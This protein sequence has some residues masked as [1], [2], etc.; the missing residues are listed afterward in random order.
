MSRSLLGPL[1][2]AALLLTGCDS[3]PAEAPIETVSLADHLPVRP[4]ANVIIVSF[5]A[6]RADALGTYG[7]PLPVSP[8][9]D[10]FAANSFVFERAYSAAPVTPTSF[11]GAFTG[12]L[13]IQSFRGWNL[14]EEETLALA[15]QRAGY[16][17]AGFFNNVQVTPERFFDRGFDDYRLYKSAR[18][19][20]ILEE[21]Q[22]WVEKNHS[23]P[24]FAWF[25]FIDP[26]SPYVAREGSQ[27]LYTPGY[28]GPFLETTKG[29]FE[30]DDP[31]D[32][33]RIRELYDGEILAADSLFGE[34]FETF[35]TL[36]LLE[37][38]IIL[39]TADHG[40]EFMERGVFQHRHL[41]D[42][43]TRIPLIL[44]H[45]DLAQPMRSSV[46]VSNLDFL[47]S[48]TD[49]VGIP[50]RDD[51]FGMSWRGE[52]PVPRAIPS[53]AMTDGEYRGAHLTFGRH[54]LVVTCVPQRTRELFDLETDPGETVDLA[55]SQPELT[56][57]LFQ[58]LRASFSS[59][60][61]CREIQRA[62]RGVDPTA[63]LKPESIK[64]LESLGYL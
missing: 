47:P 45:P 34:I 24:F 28:E 9:L 42:E 62:V 23:E 21:V 31:T 60:D 52:L 7:S 57:E 58:R 36:G 63:G 41:H 51:L 20:K 4:N 12:K 25:H 53:I 54:R 15:F 43:T 29:K 3:T 64:E 38:S 32:I 11:A 49:L 48:L 56:E 26:H 46:P 6:L 33:R 14:V 37:N 18:D 30:A 8:H 40:E 5:D 50:G 22:S 2:L 10:A 17:T 19:T 39:F 16:R 35:K 44:H 1:A 55:P 27:H 13:P 61:P 59:E